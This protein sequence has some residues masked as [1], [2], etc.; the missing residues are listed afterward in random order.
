MENNSKSVFFRPKI[1]VEVES[2]TG[3]LGFLWGK[4]FSW[5]M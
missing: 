2:V 4:G 1:T 3:W 5:L